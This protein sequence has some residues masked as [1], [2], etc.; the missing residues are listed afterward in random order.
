MGLRSRVFGLLN[1]ALRSVDLKLVQ[2]PR[3][4]DQSAAHRLELGACHAIAAQVLSAASERRE[5]S[6]LQ[7][8]AHQ[9]LGPSEPS[10]LSQPFR[11]RGVLVEPQP[12]MAERLRIRFA[13]DPSIT[14]VQCAV[15][16]CQKSVPFY[17]VDDSGGDL[18]DWTSQIA[19]FRRSHLQRFEADVPGLSR[20]IRELHV[21]VETPSQICDQSGISALDL[22]MIDVE[23]WD[24]EVIR[25][26]PFE[27][28]PVQLVVFEHG[29]LN[30]ADR[31]AAVGRLLGLGFR[32]Q[33]LSG[34]A[35]AVRP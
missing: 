15:G 26:F 9:A 6:F 4:L 16:E 28:L 24:W 23:G 29:H 19:S 7:I 25:L 8:G 27:R 3:S 32:I 30:R 31:R 2:S 34:D 14:V 33:L 21:D 22:L 20:R 17:V 5:F 12:R 18:P 13:S 35:L 11:R 1:A 10:I